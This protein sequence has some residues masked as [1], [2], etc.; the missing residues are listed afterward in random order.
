MMVTRLAGTRSALAGFGEAKR[1]T[2]Q[3]TA[4]EGRGPPTADGLRSRPVPREPPG[5]TQPQLPAGSQPPPGTGRKTQ[6]SHA[7]VPGVC[8]RTARTVVLATKT[9]AACAAAVAATHGGAASTCRFTK[10]PDVLARPR[11]A[12][13][14]RC[15]CVPPFP[16]VRLGAPALGR[17]TAPCHRVWPGGKWER[18]TTSRD[19][20]AGTT[21][22]CAPALQ[23]PGVRWDLP[24]RGGRGT[25][26]QR[27][28][29][30]RR[31]AG[32]AL[33]FSQSRAPAETRLP[34]LAR[35]LGA[36]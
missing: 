31:G 33:R 8:K 19:G 10:R 4:S 15:A 17:V 18:L 13:C 6:G 2:W 35:P 26:L 28:R 27:A 21:E 5:K 20:L 1:P 25:R 7:Q 30:S 12:A 3:G 22:P 36:E 24:A 23:P 11:S 9:A 16:G 29:S 32:G 14:P 34:L